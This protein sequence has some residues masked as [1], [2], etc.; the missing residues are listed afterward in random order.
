MNE[1][2]TPRRRGRPARSAVAPET[3]AQDTP[4]IEAAEGAKPT[5]RR[6][7]GNNGGFHLKLKVPER[8]GF[9]RRWFNDMP[10]RLAEAGELAYDHVTDPAIK[11]D[12]QDSN[13]RRLVGTQANGQP[14]YAYL[15]ETPLEEYRAGQEE[16][17]EGHR[18]IDK[19]IREGRDATG[20]VDNSYGEGS[21]S[22]G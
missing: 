6:R 7:R 1:A 2:P 12:S 10:G 8:D 19:A 9:H 5:R 15:M 4:A 16:K 18:Q 17:E 14:L 22:A 3:V 21:I 11:S 13:V 20:R